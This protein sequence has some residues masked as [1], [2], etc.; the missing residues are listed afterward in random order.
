M[1]KIISMKSILFKNKI[2]ARAR[3]PL[4]GALLEIHPP[5]AG[6]KAAEKYGKLNAAL[7]APLRWKYG[8]ET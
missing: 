8:P 4:C 5:G 1:F 6:K 3:I 7:S 2:T